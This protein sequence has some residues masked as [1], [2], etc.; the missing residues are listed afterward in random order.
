[1]TEHPRIYAEKGGWAATGSA[2]RGDEDFSASMA[3][4]GI[5]WEAGAVWKDDELSVDMEITRRRRFRIHRASG[6]LRRKF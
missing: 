1:M 5:A 6:W 3:I 2:V 4:L